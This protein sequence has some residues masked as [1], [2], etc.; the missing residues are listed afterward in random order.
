MHLIY[1]I[2]NYETETVDSVEQLSLVKW[3][4]RGEEGG[5]HVGTYTN[6]LRILESLE[7]DQTLTSED[8]TNDVLIQLIKDWESKY[9]LSSFI[10]EYIRNNP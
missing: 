10:E 3:T 5:E 2:Q 4:V 1:E 9:N 7:S 6:N 8:I